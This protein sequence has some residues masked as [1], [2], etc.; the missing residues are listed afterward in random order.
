MHFSGQL[1]CCLFQDK[2]TSLHTTEKGRGE[3]KALQITSSAEDALISLILWLSSEVGGSLVMLMKNSVMLTKLR[4]LEFIVLLSREK[5]T[6]QLAS[7]GFSPH[8]TV[9]LCFLKNSSHQQPM[10]I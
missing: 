8:S 10:D 7:T 6:A 4:A 3:S 5:G 1:A 9:H 2:H